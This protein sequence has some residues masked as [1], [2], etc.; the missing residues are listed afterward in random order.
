MSKKKVLILGVSYSSRLSLLR[1]ISEGGFEVSV[2]AWKPKNGTLPKT[3]DSCSKY[4]KNVYQC[5]RTEDEIVKFLLQYNSDRNDK[6]VLIPDCD[7]SV[8]V[9]DKNYD[10][11]KQFYFIPNIKNKQGAAVEWMNKVKQKELASAVGMSVADA[12]VIH[13]ISGKFE[14]PK[15]VKY[16]CFP[17]PLASVVGGKFGMV[18]CSNETELMVSLNSMKD[19][20]S[21]DLDVL[22]EEYK[23][24]NTEYAVLGFSDGK[25]V[26]IPAVLELLTV[27]KSHKGIAAV[28]KVVPVKGFAEIVNKFK[29][30]VGEIG[31]VGMFDVDFYEC[32]GQLYFGELNIRFGGSGYAVVKMGVNLPLMCVKCLLGENWKDM[33]MEI[34]ESGM[35]VNERMCLDDFIKGYI[36]YQEYKKMI[37]MQG[38]HFIADVED[39]G[40]QRRFKFFENRAR[41]TH[42]I[43]C[44]PCFKV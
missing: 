38:V 33:K 36:S 20:W 32:D 27:S 1:S 44:I 37:S 5:V 18:K 40:P 14:I 17:K 12:T 6:I 9:V 35:Y 2:V 43:R 24:I 11:L 21:G 26:V 34:N 41:M 8:A 3:V 28:G 19:N 42:L 39:K 31:L 23:E 15:D 25:D 13:I 16:P 22:V 30:F 7:T 4:V 29:A 10:L